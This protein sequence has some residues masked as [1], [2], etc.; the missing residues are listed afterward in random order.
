MYIN[1]QHI[2]VIEPVAPSSRV[3]QLIKET[4]AQQPQPQATQPPPSDGEA[5]K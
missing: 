1:R 3:A 2:V 5:G 4:K